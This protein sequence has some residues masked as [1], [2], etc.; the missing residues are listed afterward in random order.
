LTAIATETRSKS[1][2]IVASG[3]LV[4]L[5]A[6]LGVGRFVYTPI[7][8]VFAAALHLT[9][10]EAGLIASA[11]FVGYLVGAI[12]ASIPFFGH[13]RR[14]WLMAGLAT[15]ALA[16]LAMTGTTN[17][18]LFMLIRLVAGIASGFVMVCGSALVMERLTSA[19]R[20]SLWSVYFIGPGAGIACS[21]VLVAVLIQLQVD[22]IGL[23]LANGLIACVALAFVAWAIPGD[24][25]QA[26]RTTVSSTPTK[27]SRQI[28]L[29]T[30]AY[31]LVGFGYVIT[32][33]FI[34]ALV[35]ETPSI[36][37]FEPYVWV[38]V[39]LAAIP[40]AAFWAYW[41]ARIGAMRAFAI[42]AVTEA[43][44]V[45]A[46]VLS[47]TVLGIALAAILLGGT[48]IGLTSMG[49]VAVQGMMAENKQRGI[50]ILTAAF[51]IGQIVGPLLA[52]FMR[53]LTGSFT[54]VTYIAA[55]SL[56]VSAVLALA[57]E[58]PA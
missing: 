37:G 56:I 21:A 32:S 52:G 1:P 42:A 7:L 48:F 2:L 54:E 27:L 6:A 45:A 51:G 10:G 11:N 20:G 28:I 44:G 26:V 25:R 43:I 55:G 34:V 50:G 5:A 18:T 38:L 41:V 14:T 58:R 8:P 29:L 36:A 22:W 23:W 39:G 33:T 46:S 30:A 13:A 3:G 57:A 12:W 49:L 4:A 19:G 31:G 24:K 16:L 53:D 15:N 47:P 17:L 40:S 9:K 35:R